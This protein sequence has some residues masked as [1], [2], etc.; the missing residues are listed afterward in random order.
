[1]AAKCMHVLARSPIPEPDG[2]VEG[3]GGEPT[4]V[5]R[6]GDM[7]DNLLVSG[8]ARDRC[9]LFQRLPQEKRKVVGSREQPLATAERHSLGIARLGG[10]AFLLKILELLVLV[11]VRA[12]PEHVVGVQGQGV[13]PVAVTF[14]LR[15]HGSIRRIPDLDHAIPTCSVHGTALLDTLSRPTDLHHRCRVR[16]Q[17]ADA[18][19]AIGVPETHGVVLGSGRQLREPSFGYCMQ[20]L[21]TST[22]HRLRVPL[23]GD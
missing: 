15:D 14:Q 16:G 17:S 19:A 20:R 2:L 5:W 7:V 12:R 8:H 3:R 10:L 1:M 21:P 4:A 9:F 13:D 18:G 11:G 22:R 23:Q 6:E